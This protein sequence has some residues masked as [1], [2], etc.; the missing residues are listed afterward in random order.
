MA[1]MFE[2]AIPVLRSL[3]EAKC[4]AFYCGFLVFAVDFEH[5]F[6]PRMPLY[7]GLVRGPVKLHLSEH[8]GDAVTGSALI[9]WM[10]SIDAF[11]RELAASVARF[12]I[13]EIA[14]QP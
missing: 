3:D 7:L 11:H 9:V 2:Q 1:P 8:R 6:A 13:P 12:E 4:R 10:D 14:D 5:R